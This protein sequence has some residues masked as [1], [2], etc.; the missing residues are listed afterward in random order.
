MGLMC[1]CRSCHVCTRHTEAP[2]EKATAMLVHRVAWSARVIVT[3]IS[4][5]RFSG[6]EIKKFD[7]LC[8]A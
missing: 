5:A 3:R 7:R 8:P 6:C 2:K 4:C 1:K